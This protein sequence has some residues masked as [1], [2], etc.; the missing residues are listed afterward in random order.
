[1]SDDFSPLAVD[2][3]VRFSC[4]FLCPKNRLTQRHATLVGKPLRQTV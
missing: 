2:Y 4:A 1:L 3:T